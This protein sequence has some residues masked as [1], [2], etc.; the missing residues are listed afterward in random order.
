MATGVFTA[1]VNGRYQFNFVA[2][3]NAVNAEVELRVNGNYI[4][5][6]YVPLKDDTLAITATL[7]LQKGDKIDTYLYGGSIFDGN[8][9]YYT[10]FTGILLEED[11]V[12]S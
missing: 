2:R 8:G 3:A 5:I 12:L 4:A 11:L 1:P 7:A 10:Q 9:L 6:G